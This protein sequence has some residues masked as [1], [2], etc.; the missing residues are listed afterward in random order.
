MVLGKEFL[1]LGLGLGPAHFYKEEVALVDYVLLERTHFQVDQIFHLRQFLEVG[2]GREIQVYEVDVASS[3][4]SAAKDE[5]IFFVG[6]NFV[7]IRA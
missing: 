5:L 3:F 7:A 4:S 2:I 1:E 6:L